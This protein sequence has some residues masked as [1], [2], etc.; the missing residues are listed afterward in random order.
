MGIFFC[1]ALKIFQLAP[2]R[3][4]VIQKIMHHQTLSRRT[5]VILSI[6][7]GIFTGTSFIPFPPWAL[8]F[9]LVPL[10]MVWLN[11]S[12]YKRLFFY[13]WLA[14]FTT[15]I[16]G[17]N[18]VAYVSLE[19]GHMPWPV[20]LLVL[21]I[22]SSVANLF[23]PFAAV[24]FGFLRDKLDL[25]LSSQL[26]LM[27]LL[28]HLFHEYT[29][30][31]FPWNLGY[32]L[33]WAKAP[34]YH[35]AE[36]IGFVGLSLLVLFLNALV[37]WVWLHRK[38]QFKNMALYTILATVTVSNGLGFYISINQPA[39]DAEIKVLIVQA[40]VGNLEKVYAEQGWGFRDTIAKKYMNLTKSALSDLSEKPDFVIWPESAYPRTLDEQTIFRTSQ[41]E[42]L[43]FF[44]TLDLSL[45][46]GAYGI[47]SQQ[48]KPTNS[49]F[50]IRSGKLQEI[51]Y[52]KLHLLIFGEYIP[53]SDRWPQLKKM[54]PAGDFEPGTQPHVLPFDE[55]L[56][57]PQICYESLFPK[58]TKNVVDL[59]AEILVNVTND[60]WYGTWQEPWQHLY[61][62]VGRAVEFRRPLVRSTNT[63]ISTVAL[64]TGEVQ[65]LSPMLEEW[66]G[67]YKVHYVKNPPATIYKKLFWFIP[68]LVW[69]LTVGLIVR[70]WR[71]RIKIS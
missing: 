1:C 60:S 40:N 43:R 50:V 4:L 14:Q 38:Q 9:C 49:V 17:F 65:Q 26:L 36:W 46:T 59:G 24:T 2:P 32:P 51:H 3:R 67:F 6:V 35:L 5:A 52:S 13:G 42:L 8:L 7:T 69:L 30:T 23:M 28:T 31:V 29:P 41:S 64:A 19:F 53:F 68:A 54:I 57:G 34:A 16:I 63:G 39:P 44:A 48:G 70:A 66:T 45:I 58:Y 71:E 11:E 20:A 21:I 25:K 61:M 55:T 15:T 62:T 37:L 56:L 22:Y 27:V 10:W 47:G 18:W 12:S 33:L